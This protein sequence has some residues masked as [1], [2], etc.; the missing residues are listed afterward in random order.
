MAFKPSILEKGW[1]TKDSIFL[2]RCQKLE[3]K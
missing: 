2:N 1:V 3:A